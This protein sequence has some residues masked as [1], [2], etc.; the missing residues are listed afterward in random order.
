[1]IRPAPKAA[2]AALAACAATLATAGGAWAQASCD[3]VVITEMDWASSAIVTNVAVFLMEQGYGCDVQVVPS[4]TT[5]AMVSVAET[6]RPDIVTEVWPNGNPAYD[7]LVAEGRIETVADVLSDRSVQGWYLPTSLVDAHPELATLEGILANPGL[8]GGRLHSCPDGWQ[9][10]ET[11]EAI[12]RAAGLPEAGIE[13]FQHGSGETLAASMASAVEAGE[14]WLGYYW[15]PTGLLGKYA[16]TKVD[17]GA[18]DEEAWNCIVDP[19]CPGEEM[20]SYA[21]TP[22]V[23]VVTTTFAEDHPE[24]YELMSNVA[25]TNAQMGAVLSWQE[26]NAASAEEAA[27]H[28]LTEYRDVWPAWL[29]EDARANLAALI[30]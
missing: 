30:D 9:C 18:F 11:T 28:F 10:K 8:V 2:R 13:V 22:V 17:L 6:G 26:E 15:E 25:F 12:A 24:L 1:M 14:P 16:M 21:S 7:S 4:S 20:T 5:P 27:V 23:T 19:E 29:S 3:D